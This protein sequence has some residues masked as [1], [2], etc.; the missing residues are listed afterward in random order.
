MTKLL[1]ALCVIITSLMLGCGPTAAEIQ[2][3]K[4]TDSLTE[5]KRLIMQVEAQRLDSVKR[6]TNRILDS[7]NESKRIE[8]IRNSIK[9]TSYYLGSPNSAGG[10]DA[11][12]Y[13]KNLSD[14]AIKYLNWEGYPINAVGDAVQCTVRDRSSAGGRD[15]GP[16]KKNQ[17]GGGCWDCMW[18]NWTANKL[19]LTEVVIEYMNGGKLTI[20]GDDLYLIGKKKQ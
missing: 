16:L 7:I 20:S 13:Y 12:F 5:V 15:T 2:A 1:L 10:V 4:T 14:Q 9:I 3:K 17:T 8:L 6:E 11:Y 19:I 18:Y